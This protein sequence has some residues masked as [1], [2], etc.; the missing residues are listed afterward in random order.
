MLS[1]T[2]MIYLGLG[3]SVVYIFNSY[4]SDRD[5]FSANFMNIEKSEFGSDEAFKSDRL[6]ASF[7]PV[8]YSADSNQTLTGSRYLNDKYANF[9]SLAGAWKI[10]KYENWIEGKVKNKKSESLEGSKLFTYLLPKQNKVLIKK[11][12]PNTRSKVAEKEVLW[13]ISYFDFVSNGKTIALESKYIDEAGK[14][15][16]ERL[17]AKLVLLKYTN[18]PKI[19]AQKAKSENLGDLINDKSHIE[20]SF[21]KLGVPKNPRAIGDDVVSGSLSIK[22]GE[23][24]HLFVDLSNLNISGWEKKNIE[25]SNAKIKNNTV[26][27]DGY[28]VYVVARKDIKQYTLNFIGG[29]FNQFK[30]TFGGES[31]QR[32]EKEQAIQTAAN[33]VQGQEQRQ[34]APQGQSQYQAPQQQFSPQMEAQMQA[35]AEAYEEEMA[36]R[37]EMEM[38]EQDRIDARGNGAAVSNEA[39]NNYLENT[40]VAL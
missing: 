33:Q 14:T 25:I 5:M 39:V 36:Y 12:M 24:E 9:Q 10:F 3:L 1:F 21:S 8:S 34:V 17:Q 4:Q 30:V 23:I 20:L 6:V 31:E 18:A 40:G 15:R 26:V 38:E 32:K 13:D 22:D 7:K 35:N 37:E 19:A 28:S 11:V 29:A 27:V 2:R 16:V